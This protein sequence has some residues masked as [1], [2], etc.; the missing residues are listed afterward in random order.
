MEGDVKVD[1]NNRDGQILSMEA[2]H[3]YEEWFG[4]RDIGMKIERK[5]QELDQDLKLDNLTRGKGNCF[6]IAVLQQINR[7]EICQNVDSKLREMASI[8]NHREF[9]GKIA[10]FMLKSKLPHVQAYRKQFEEVTNTKWNKYCNKMTKNGEYVDSHFVQCTAWCLKMDIMILDENATKEKPFMKIS[11][12]EDADVKLPVL[13][14]GLSDEHY[15]SLL[16]KSDDNKVDANQTETSS[17][18]ES[19]SND[20]KDDKNQT[21]T[22]FTDFKEIK[23]CPVC[24]KESNKVLWHLSRTK[25]CKETFGA[26][27]LK[28]IVTES[29]KENVKK[30][31]SQHRAKRRAESPETFKKK[32]KLQ[33]AED[34]NVQ[35]SKDEELFKE[36]NSQAQTGCKIQ[37]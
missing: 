28:Q 3:K 33:K 4:I 31:M 7:N 10:I 17:N 36:R 25:A 20:N 11:G 18:D 29:K 8:I 16:P 21:A 27:K 37:G 32:M 35:R 23:H 19:D 34:R 26:E 22:Q 2:S 15:Q 6:P 1:L 13:F 12:S 24:G 9:R 30:C 14:I 5:A